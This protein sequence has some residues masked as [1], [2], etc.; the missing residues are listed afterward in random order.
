M[1]S[2]ASQ[3]EAY[4]TAYGPDWLR[5]LPFGS[6]GRIVATIERNGGFNQAAA[7]P[8]AGLIPQ[9]VLELEA[10]GITSQQ[11]QGLSTPASSPMG[12]AVS[13]WAVGAALAGVAAWAWS[14]SR[15]RRG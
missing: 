6:S 9:G 15:R 2:D 1:T 10:A 4:R 14:S 3:L 8:Y 7:Q 13:S 12:Q 11:V 5:A